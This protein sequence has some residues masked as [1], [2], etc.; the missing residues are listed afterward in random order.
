MI[1]AR[2][3]HPASQSRT[4]VSGSGS[5]A[6]E[7]VRV[8]ELGQM[9]SAPYCARLFAELGADV[10]KVE[11][12]E[13]DCARR[14]GPFPGG[15][16]HPEKSGLFFINNT[17]K[18]GVTC[19]TDIDPG[20]EL[21]LELLRT[22]D[23]LVENN[24]PRQMQAW[25]LDYEAIARVNPSLVVI[26]ITPYGQTGPY[27]H[28]N[29]YD[30][31]AYHLSGGSWRYCG[32][33]GQMPLQHGTYSA[34]YF[35]AVTGA[36]WGM[37]ALFGRDEIGGQHV[38]VS[39][40]EAIAATFVGAANIAATIVEGRNERRTGRGNALSAPATILPCRDG[41]V[42]MMVMEPGQWR[43]LRAAMGEPAWAQSEVF[44]DTRARAEHEDIVYPMVTEWCRKRSKMELMELCQAHG[45]PVSAILDIAEVVEQ[46]HLHERGY[47]VDVEH[48]YLGKVR[49]M[50]APFRMSGSPAPSPCPAPLLGQHNDEVWRQRVGLSAADV[51][52][53]RRQG[54]L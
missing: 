31:N 38:D 37:A 1:E 52:R 29:G 50:G 48:A 21:F 13:G 28:W 10:V 4:V 19:R 41:H 34:D 14:I 6:L 27:S 20:R 35:G 53:L 36:A 15:E 45:C 26:S 25:R 39:C 51:A 5:R 22:S 12:P 44:D 54:V 17:D 3:S 42:W 18:R 23:V 43:G 46:P 47:F 7:G 30:L 16:R 49:V 32:N 33:P 9:V 40:A 11:P 8:T 24:L 2:T